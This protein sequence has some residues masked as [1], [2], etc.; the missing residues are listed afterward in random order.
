MACGCDPM[1]LEMK[2]R[3]MAMVHVYCK[4]SS[5]GCMVITVCS[6]SS[7]CQEHSKGS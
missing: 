7:R 2:L 6:V 1:I 3:L 4:H 5:A